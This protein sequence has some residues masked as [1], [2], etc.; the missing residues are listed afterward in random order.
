M[1][2]LTIE[3]LALGD[4]ILGADAPYYMSG[5]RDRLIDADFVIGQ[6]EIPYS[7]FAEELSGLNRE[8]KTLEPLVG[9]I[10]LV[11]LAGNHIY[12]AR[13]TGVKETTA[14]LDAHGILHVGGGM[15]TDEARKPIITVQNEVRLGFLNYNCIGPANMT[16]M[17][18]KAGCAALDIITHYEQKNVAN[19]GGSPELIHTFPEWRSL[20]AMCH[21]IERLRSECDV[22]CVYFHKGI[23]HKPAVIADY[24]QIIS[25]AAIES[26]A[27]VVFSSHAHILHGIEIYKGKTIYHGLGNGVVWA[28]SLR[29]DYQF[30]SKLKP[31][32]LFNPMDWAQKRYERFGFISDPSYP[33]YPFHPEAVN[34]LIA[35]CLIAD[36]RIIE[37]RCIPAIVGHDGV[38]RHVTKSGGGCQVFE[39]LNMIT[40]QAGLNARYRWDGDEIVIYS[41]KGD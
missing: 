12:D 15:N 27:D 11:T 6:L 37:T 14:W 20:K 5:I 35:K 36:K 29:P 16:A 26:G 10:D 8:T 32:E 22:L 18:N 17:D 40:E 38:T 31:N 13:E 9:C 1:K 28:P 23:V 34:T 7:D 3:M 25:Y 19:P 21:D 30:S 24:E 41:E 39:Y 33:T 2:N 4:I